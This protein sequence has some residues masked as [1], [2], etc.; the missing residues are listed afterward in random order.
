ML[1]KDFVGHKIKKKSH[2]HYLTSVS[3]TLDFVT[4]VNNMSK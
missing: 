1:V 3:H 4:R 2:Y